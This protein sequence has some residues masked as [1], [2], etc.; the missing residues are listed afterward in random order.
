MALAG[1]LQTVP[2]LPQLE[3]SPVRSTQEPSQ[4]VSVPQSV[5]QT[6]DLQT[7]PG[8]QTAVQLPQWSPSARVSTQRLPHFV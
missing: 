4:A 2:H 1:A 3:V 7:L 5:E 6:P 8:S